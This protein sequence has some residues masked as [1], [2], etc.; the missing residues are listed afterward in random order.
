CFLHGG[1]SSESTLQVYRA[2]PFASGLN[3]VLG[4]I[5]NLQEA[6]AIN[7]DY[8][9]GT[10]PAI[11]SPA[12]LRLGHVVI[13]CCHPRAPHLEFAHGFSVPWN[14]ASIVNRAYVNERR[15]H[16]LL[17]AGEVVLVGAAA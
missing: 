15:S 9:A 17:A 2:D 5:G 14:F 11:S 6:V 4:A 16:T 7:R 8:V 1:M 12:I 10:Q 13:A 3:Q